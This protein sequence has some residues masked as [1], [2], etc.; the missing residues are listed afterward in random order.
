MSVLTITKS[1]FN[2]TV[3]KSDKPVLL[4]FWA[5]WCM[6]CKMLSP[7]IDELAEEYPE[8]KFGKVNVDEQGELAAKYGIAS[9]PTLLFFRGGEIVNKSVGYRAK[10]A[11]AELIS[12]S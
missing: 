1:N 5:S 4:D 7:V 9:I 12:E 10:E 2:E 6:P 3:L 11:L 8:V